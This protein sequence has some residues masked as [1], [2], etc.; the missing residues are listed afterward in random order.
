AASATRLRIIAAAAKL[1]TEHGYRGTTMPAIAEEAGVSVQSVHLAGPKRKLLMV[2]FDL[3]YIGD[4]VTSTLAHRPTFSQLFSTEPDPALTTYCRFI[5]DRNEKS[6]G[7]YHALL[8]A[9]ESDPEVTTLV[10]ALDARRHH[11]IVDGVRWADERGLLSGVG[12]FDQRAEV[13]AFL[14]SPETYRYYVVLRNWPRELYLAWLRHSIEQL[15]FGEP[16]GTA[17]AEFKASGD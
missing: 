5:A 11:D 15:V 8:T 12:T 14:S 9:G 17:T 6:Y 13:W 7:V 16:V 3:A 10:A 4:E 1:F 2:A